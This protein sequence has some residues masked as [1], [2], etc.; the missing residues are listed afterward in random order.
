M[1]V[2]PNDVDDR[3]IEAIRAID[4]YPDNVVGPPPELVA[5]RLR[6]REQ[7]PSGHR[8]SVA[9]VVSR[10]NAG[11]TNRMLARAIDAPLGVG[12]PHR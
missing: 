8:R 2:G 3:L 12:A 9:V 4:P 6:E 1:N 7:D 5:R 11:I 10:Y